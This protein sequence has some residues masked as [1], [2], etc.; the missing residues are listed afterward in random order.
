M[1]CVVDLLPFLHWQIPETFAALMV[2]PH[3]IRQ[4]LT[5]DVRSQ[6]ALAAP[7]IVSE[8]SGDFAGVQDVSASDSVRAVCSSVPVVRNFVG[9]NISAAGQRAKALVS[10]SQ[11]ETVTDVPPE[12]PLPAVPPSIPACA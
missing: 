9:T 7:V 11:I 4:R 8:L 5:P 2:K 1:K 6:R 3:T 10:W 12:S